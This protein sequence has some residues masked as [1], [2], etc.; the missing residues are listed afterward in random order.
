MNR[1]GKLQN[2]IKAQQSFL[3]VGLDPDLNR[4]PQGIS[5]TPEGVVDFCREIVNSTIDHCA[6]YKLNF[7]FFEA[8]GEDGWRILRKCREL[9]PDSHYVIADAKRGDIGNT[10]NKYA[11]AI[12]NVL[13]FD[14]V[15][16]SGYMG[17]DSVDPFLEFEDRT[18][19][20][21]A[22]TSNPGSADFQLKKLA[23]GRCVYEDVIKTSVSWAGPDRLMYVVGATHS[24]V[25]K[26]IR[27]WIPDHFLL[28]PGVGAQ[29]GSLQNVVKFGRGKSDINLLINS[30][31][32]IIYASENEDFA[33]AAKI[34]ASSIQDQM[35]NLIS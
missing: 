30:S 20:L 18:V 15:T 9:I 23:S 31:R 4:L 7:A 14:A 16:I 35:K 27:K 29:G 26:E 5:R 24:Y 34:A 6:A 10:A 21:L 1:I 3:C 17:R 28:V 32:G 25:F 11:H 12:F 33:Q 2:S 8:L 13:D 19:I 22:L